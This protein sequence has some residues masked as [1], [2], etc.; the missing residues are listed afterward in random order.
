VADASHIDF[1]QLRVVVVHPRD[2]DGEI[3]FRYLQRLGCQ[4]DQAWPPP[5][6]LEA[7]Q[8]VLFCLIHPSARSLLAAIVE[9]PGTA[10]VGIIDPATTGTLHVL[11]DLSPQTVLHKPVD[12][13]AILT[14]MVV[15]RNNARYQKRLLAK[16][17][18]LE[19]TLRSVRKVERAKTILMETR[20][21]DES[22]AGD[23]Q[24]RANRRRGLGCRGIEGNAFG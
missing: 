13:P 11:S 8:D 3:L 16:I 4:V 10:V 23:A 14:N 18:K 5:P 19:E 21:M 6:R 20:N 17:C 7:N 15:A 22:R 12:V 24:A 2:H 1:R 9:S